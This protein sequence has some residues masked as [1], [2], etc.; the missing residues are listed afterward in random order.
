[1]NSYP[2]W[3]CLKRTAN[4]VTCPRQYLQAKIMLEKNRMAGNFL[5]IMASESIGL[6]LGNYE[7]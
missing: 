7:D 5:P 1:M 6:M 4:L 2:T 3:Q